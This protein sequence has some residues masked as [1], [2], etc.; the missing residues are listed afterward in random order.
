[1]ALEEKLKKYQEKIK[2][3]PLTSVIISITLLL[4]LLIVVPYLDVSHRGINN[5]TVEATLENQY[6]ATLA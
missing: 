1:M 2:Q 4:L 3:N 5:A 6:R